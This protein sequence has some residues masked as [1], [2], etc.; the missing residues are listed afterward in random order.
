MK[1]LAIGLVAASIAAPSWADEV[2]VKPLLDLRLRWE[3]VDQ[4]GIA[5]DA[6]A[7]TLRARPGFVATT[8][9]FS[10]LAEAEGTVALDNH[11]FS[12]L[13]GK[14]QYPLVADPQTLEVNRFQLQ[15]HPAKT[16]TATVGRQLINIEDQRF[17][18]GEPLDAV[19]QER[20][21]RGGHR[22]CSPRM[23]P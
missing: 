2:K 8:G 13:N 20:A 4:T 3:N 1:R 15:Y 14:T 22:A 17:V 10:L 21:E 5:K 11:Y 7:V 19:A 6:D 12:G 9:A 23:P 16:L 18:G